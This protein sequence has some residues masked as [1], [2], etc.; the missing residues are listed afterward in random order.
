LSQTFGDDRVYSNIEYPVGGGNWAE[1][2]AL[3]WLGDHA[4]VIEAKGHSISD[5]FRAGAMDYAQFH[6]DDVVDKA[7]AQS[8]RAAAY[9][10][11]G[12]TELRRKNGGQAIDWQP[13]SKATR[14]AVSFERIDPF[15]LAAARV[16]QEQRSA[17]PTWVVCLADLLLV[18]DI[19]A[20]PHEFFA[21]AALRAEL[22]ANPVVALLS[23]ADALGAFLHD[24][25]Q[26]YKG[27]L[28]RGRATTVMLDHHAGRLNEYYSSL[29]VGLSVAK[30]SLR[31]PAEKV[32]QL[33]RLYATR[34]KKWAEEARRLVTP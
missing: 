10:V 23:E 25:L 19:L 11:S 2:D 16:A 5:N 13:V 26:A 21:Y 15:V 7:F 20:E 17:P 29:D 8:G 14:I 6:F 4:L 33:G 28:K 1:V 27:L 30:P 12:G 3:V 22:A 32:E 9:L 24:R 18:G 34:S 31:I